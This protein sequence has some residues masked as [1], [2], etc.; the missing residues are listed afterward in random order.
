V[1]ENPVF[2]KD[3]LSVFLLRLK[4]VKKMLKRLGN[5]FK[6]VSVEEKEGNYSRPTRHIDYGGDI[7]SYC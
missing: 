6:R 1:W 7:G 3:R 2:G 4:N 5:K